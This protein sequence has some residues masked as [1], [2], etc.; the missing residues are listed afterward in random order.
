MQNVTFEFLRNNLVQSKKTG[1]KPSV[2][3]VTIHLFIICL[4][5]RLGCNCQLT[6]SGNG[7]KKPK[8]KIRY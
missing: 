7:P 5:Y 1:H 2:R 8:L 6:P 4:W 3:S